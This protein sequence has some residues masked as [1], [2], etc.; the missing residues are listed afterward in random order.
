MYLRKQIITELSK[1]QESITA[2]SSEEKF[3]E[4]KIEVGTIFKFLQERTESLGSRSVLVFEEIQKLAALIQALDVNEKFDAVQKEIKEVINS[5]VTEIENKSQVITTL[6]E[7]GVSRALN[8]ISTS[9]D[10]LASR[11]TQAQNEIGILC[12]KN[13]ASVFE[14]VT[15]IKALLAQVDENNVSANNAI[16]SSITDRLSIFETGLRDS[17]ELQEKTV[18]QSSAQL[19][20][21]FF[22]EALMNL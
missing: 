13:F 21:Q 10:S 18:L 12:E 17:L 6:N 4:L 1:L 22:L 16:F 19:V 7:A 5:V 11:L 3:N 2:V 15:E 9:A 20:E 14:R 8:E